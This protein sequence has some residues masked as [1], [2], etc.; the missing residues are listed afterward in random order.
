MKSSASE[1]GLIIKKASDLGRCI[2]E[3]T[4]VRL[5]K[6]RLFEFSFHSWVTFC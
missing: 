3:K 2:K 5:Y 4:S 6:K 1:P